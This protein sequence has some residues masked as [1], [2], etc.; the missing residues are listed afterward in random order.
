[1]VCIKCSLGTSQITH[2][3]KKIFPTTNVIK[4]P[5][6]RR[7]NRR[8]LWILRTINSW[9]AYIQSHAGNLLHLWKLFL[10]QGSTRISCDKVCTGRNHAKNL[11]EIQLQT[12]IPARFCVSLK[13]K[14]KHWCNSVKYSEQ[15]NKILGRIHSVQ[16]S[17]A[18]VTQPWNH[19]NLW[20]ENIENSFDWHHKEKVWEFFNSWVTF[21][22]SYALLMPTRLFLVCVRFTYK[23]RLQ[24]DA[25]Q[26]MWKLRLPPS[27]TPVEAGS[28]T[29][30]RSDLIFLSL[31]KW[32]GLLESWQ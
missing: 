14:V 6:Y 2:A 1:M 25:G 18:K 9:W 7:I 5:W 27:Q 11:L 12:M 24:R 26:L 15:S 30:C 23:C 8:W 28:Q 3:Y 10:S 19:L 13:K 16:I 17:P 32:Q 31:T 22:H 21:V 20:K 4:L 29:E